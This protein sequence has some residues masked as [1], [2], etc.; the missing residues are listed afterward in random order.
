MVQTK[1]IF[2]FN[3]WLVIFFTTAVSTLIGQF[4]I[5]AEE[6]ESPA[7]IPLVPKP[8]VRLIP[9]RAQI[10]YTTQGLDRLEISGAKTAQGFANVMYEGEVFSL[11]P[12]PLQK[13]KLRF[14]EGCI[15]AVYAQ[16][17][18]A[19]FNVATESE[20]WQIDADALRISNLNK[21]TGKCIL[22]F[23]HHT[24]EVFDDS[25]ILLD[26][27]NLLLLKGHVKLDGNQS[28]FESLRVYRIDEKG[29]APLSILKPKEFNQKW[30]PFRESFE[31]PISYENPT[32]RLRISPQTGGGI[33]KF[34]QSS[35]NTNQK[36]IEGGRVQVDFNNEL[37]KHW[38]GDN[39]AL[40]FGLQFRN[41]GDHQ[42]QYTPSESVDV[43]SEAPIFYLGIRKRSQYWFSSYWTIGA[44]KEKAKVSLNFPSSNYSRYEQDAF[45][46][47]Y[48]SYGFDIVWRFPSLPWLGLI[49]G[50]EL[51]AGTS[52]W[53]GERE[54]Q[55]Q[56]GNNPRPDLSQ[57]PWAM[58]S[59]AG[60]F[61][62]GIYGAYYSDN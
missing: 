33:L 5:A 9:W 4:C 51:Q 20:K 48:L 8:P 17:A 32:Y 40:I 2:D 26:R 6:L 34:D 54:I 16:K 42:S 55:S 39:R 22:D 44:S 57:E 12:G 18:Q 41:I 58:R 30:P 31:L 35:L 14:R 45:Y 56:N 47:L 23:N 59:L 19:K 10:Q 3:H 38:V 21:A 29:K 11:S 60:L 15:L 25:E 27:Q 49:A 53:R 43:S 24:V 37:A 7:S 13:T 46:S 61:Y 50:A 28:D 1:K 52:L 62:I 36:N